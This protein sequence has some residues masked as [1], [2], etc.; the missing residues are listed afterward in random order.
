[1]N[2]ATILLVDDDHAFV[3][4]LA[5]RLESNNYLTLRAYRATQ[6]LKILQSEAVDLV[7]TDL[8]MAHMDGFE[9]FEKIKSDHFGM[10]VIMMT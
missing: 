8:K 2:R 3:E 9:L 5:M 1:M 4:L 7:I 10:P 6:A